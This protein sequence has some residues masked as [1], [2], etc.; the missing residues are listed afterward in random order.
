MPD[1]SRIA[2][3]ETVIL[4]DGST[5]QAALSTSAPTGSEVGL[6]VRNV[7]SGSQ[8]VR[9]T[10][11][12]ASA[13]S[14]GAIYA[15]VAGYGILRTSPENTSLFYDP[16]DGALDTTNRWNAATTANG[17][18]ATQA[19]GGETIS[20]GTAL[21]GLSFISSQPSFVGIVPGFAQIGYAIKLEATPYTTNAVRFWG[22]GTHTTT[23]TTT[24]PLTEGCGWE[25]TTTGSLQAVV[26]NA[27]VRTLVQDLSAVQKTD[28]A[29]HR[30]A[31][32]MRTDRCYWYIDSLDVP[33]AVS[34]FN[35]PQT[36]TLPLRIQVIN[37]ASST[38]A[39][40]PTIVCTGVAVG[41][42]GRNNTQISDGTYAWRKTT[43]MNSAPVGTEYGQVVRNIPS[44]TQ[45]VSGTVTV[46]SSTV[47]I[48]ATSVTQPV[49]GTVTLS[50]SNITTTGSI[51]TSST[52]IAT[53]DISTYGAVAISISGTYA[54]VNL[55]FEASLDSGT[56]WIG[57]EGV[58]SDSTAGEGTTGVLTANTTR[59][60]SVNTV[61]GCYTNVRV[62]STAFTSGSASVRIIATKN[63]SGRE[64]V[65]T[66]DCNVGDPDTSNSP[67]KVGGIAKTTQPTASADNAR[68]AALHDSIGRQIV[69]QGHMRQQVTTTQITATTTASTAGLAAVASTFLDITQL[70]VSNTSATA[71]R[72][73]LV[74]G[75][76]VRF[77]VYLA[78]SGGGAVIPFNPPL[79]Q[80]VV[81]TAWNIQLSTA[82]TD[83]RVF[84][85]AVK[86]I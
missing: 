60:W 34:N 23:P 21:S 83:V 36:Q 15:Q 39:S 67:I 41:D 8:D 61:G 49:S 16:F 13:Y 3:A 27:G 55:T 56:T 31:M 62:R 20:G 48:G 81:N 68:V 54:G 47:T 30:Y 82:V 59:L 37:S 33:V 66:G 6:I 79:P 44:G 14:G 73:D 1:L 46:G 57:V 74:D 29:Y 70:V 58:R 69:V 50:S 22:V 77:S 42:S 80:A 7:P 25:I 24:T 76:T 38:P 86:N 78:A 9:I 84:M 17:G 71:V 32:W 51:T 12:S 2:S 18:S 52:T 35:F 26:Y 40:A 43:V 45:A 75:V 4:T 53:G 64:V 72:V 5:Q 19:N 28:G 85:Q 11:P 10:T 65:V 63:S